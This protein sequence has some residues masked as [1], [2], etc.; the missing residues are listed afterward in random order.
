MA[1]FNKSFDKVILAEGGYV[2]DPDDAGGETYLGISRKNNP[3]WAGWEVID[4]IKSKYGIKGITSRLKQDIA[5]TNSAKLLY[6]MKY[7][8]IMN[9]D[10]V[11]NQNIAHGLFDTAVNMGITK[12]TRIAQDICGMPKTGIWTAELEYKIQHYGENF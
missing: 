7:W 2:N 5:L 6:K 9:L 1:D 4:E 12:A 10:K 11:K 3:T 8:D